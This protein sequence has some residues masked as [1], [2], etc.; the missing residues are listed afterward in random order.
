[1]HGFV[2]THQGEAGPQRRP[3]DARQKPA[4]L[5]PELGLEPSGHDAALGKLKDDQN[6]LE[7]TGLLFDKQVVLRDPV[8]AVVI[9]GV[10]EHVARR[11]LAGEL[12]EACDGPEI[13][14]VAKGKREERKAPN[15]HSLQPQAG[16]PY[17][18]RI[19]G[20]PASDRRG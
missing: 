13:D 4:A 16:N 18:R 2:L 20:S 7:P 19:Y 17:I 9:S 8:R 1:M 5:R 3:L 15:R 10:G 11:R 6:V 14:G 12:Y